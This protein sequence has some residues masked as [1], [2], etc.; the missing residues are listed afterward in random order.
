MKL[1]SG[2][3]L[4]H[5]I[6]LGT[7]KSSIIAKKKSNNLQEENILLRRK[8]VEILEEILSGLNIAK[9]FNKSHSNGL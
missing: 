2:A 8:V 1:K 5:K 6:I 3:V 9:L 4:Q 7:A